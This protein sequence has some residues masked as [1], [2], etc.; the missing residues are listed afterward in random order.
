MVYI[1]LK[2][3][4]H[5]MYCYYAVSVVSLLYFFPNIKKTLFLAKKS[6]TAD[7]ENFS[8][9]LYSR[10]GNEQQHKVLVTSTQ[11]RY[12]A[13]G[14]NFLP[15][16]FSNCTFFLELSKLVNYGPI[17]ILKGNVMWQDGC[18]NVFIKPYIFRIG[19]ISVSLKTLGSLSYVVF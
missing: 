16:Q 7:E 8:S 17:C 18:N 4:H 11:Y 13:Q 9:Q 15:S 14:V 5:N 1:V 12:Q 2:I 3:L 19:R 6:T 10:R